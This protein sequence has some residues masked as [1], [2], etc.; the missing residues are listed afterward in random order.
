MSEHV[1]SVYLLAIRLC[2][3]NAERRNIGMLLNEFQDVFSRSDTDVEQMHLVEHSI[4]VKPLEP[5]KEAKVEWQIKE[6][7]GQGLITPSNSAWSSPVV[8]VKQKD[9]NWHFCIDYRQLNYVTK[10]D[11]QPLSRINESLEL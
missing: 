10:Q 1:N 4:P 6:L 7:S 3:F 8:L 2:N 5:Q 11:C 9:G